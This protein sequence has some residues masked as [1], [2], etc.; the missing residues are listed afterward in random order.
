M[1]KTKADAKRYEASGRCKVGPRASRAEAVCKALELVGYIRVAS[2]EKSYG[3]HTVKMR[4]KL[5]PFI[6]STSRRS[7]IPPVFASLNRLASAAMSRQATLACAPKIV[8]LYKVVTVI[9]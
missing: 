7:A 5:K 3:R 8:R 4:S 6:S 9:C 2:L 1:K